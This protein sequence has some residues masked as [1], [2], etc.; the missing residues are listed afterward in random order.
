ML[1]LRAGVKCF[2]HALIQKRC[3]DN[4]HGELPAQLNPDPRVG[5]P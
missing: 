3:V 5:G 2:A 4:P 1:S